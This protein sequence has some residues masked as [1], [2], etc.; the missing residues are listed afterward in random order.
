MSESRE[1]LIKRLREI[2]NEEIKV[3]NNKLSAMCYC[4]ALAPTIRFKCEECYTKMEYNMYEYKY[5]CMC[6]TIEEI[7]NLGYDAKIKVLCSDCLIKAK[8]VIA[9]HIFVHQ[10]PILQNLC[11]KNS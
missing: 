7:R 8:K 4:P 3:E 1:E 6:E 5:K 9:Q 11:T 10:N 2:A